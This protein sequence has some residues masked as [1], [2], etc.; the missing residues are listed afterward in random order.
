MQDRSAIRSNARW[1][2]WRV[3]CVANRWM[4]S[5]GKRMSLWPL[6]VGEENTAARLDTLAILDV[7]TRPI[8]VSGRKDPVSGAELTEAEF[9]E[10]LADD[11]GPGRQTAVEDPRVAKLRQASGAYREW[12]KGQLDQVCIAAQSLRAYN[13]LLGLELATLYRSWFRR[14]PNSDLAK[15]ELA[16]YRRWRDA[17]T[18]ESVLAI[19]R[20]RSGSELL[21]ALG[22][23]SPPRPRAVAK[24]GDDAAKQTPP[25]PNRE[26]DPV[27][28]L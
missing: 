21:Q 2:W 13:E 19:T 14:I 9:N 25:P 5:P 15:A 6:P 22:R 23:A 12:L 7:M 26:P 16:A 17:L 28:Q 11:D 20:A 24:P 3:C 1:R 18:E 10:L 4:S 27:L 8:A